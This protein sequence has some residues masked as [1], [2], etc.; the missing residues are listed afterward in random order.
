MCNFQVFYSVLAEK[1]KI[2]YKMQSEKY[3]ALQTNDKNK[4]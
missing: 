4:V 2:K 3:T 1:Y